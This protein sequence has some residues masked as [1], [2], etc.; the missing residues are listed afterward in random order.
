[1]SW[2]RKGVEKGI[3]LVEVMVVIVL[4]M[5]LAGLLSPA[6]MQAKR[7]AKATVCT[8]NLRTC[9]SAALIYAADYDDL[10]PLGKDCA[11]LRRPDAWPTRLQT[12]I[13]AIP[14]LSDQLAAYGV[15]GEVW[16]CPLDSGIDVLDAQPNMSLSATPS[17]FADCGMSFAYNTAAGIAGLPFTAVPNPSAMMYLQDQAGHWHPNVP[18]LPNGVSGSQTSD[19]T[20]DFRYNIV[21]VDGHVRLVGFQEARRAFG[22]E[23]P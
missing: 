22:G 6:L 19:W 13:K 8:S 2:S 17:L 3:T 15:K 23:S 9:H 14:L 4:I 10:W 18:R 20:R 21:F 16:S 11:D 12:R 7:R 5:S 1:M